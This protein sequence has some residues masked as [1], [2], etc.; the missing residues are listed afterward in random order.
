MDDKIL[1]ELTEL[2]NQQINDNNNNKRFNKEKTLLEVKYCINVASLMLDQVLNKSYY[3]L[4][5]D[6]QISFVKHNNILSVVVN[7][8]FPYF[9]NSTFITG[10]QKKLNKEL[11]NYCVEQCLLYLRDYDSVYQ[12]VVRYLNYTFINLI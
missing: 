2:I 6:E 7:V 12:N 9:Y 3:P 10:L 8:L 11:E 1:S 4:M 5:N